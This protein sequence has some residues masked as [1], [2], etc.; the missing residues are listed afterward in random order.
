MLRLNR[1]MSGF[2]KRVSSS[3]KPFFYVFTTRRL[4]PK[5]KLSI[6]L[7]LWLFNIFINLLNKICF[8]FA[9]IFSDR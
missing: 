3:E 5:S 9:D 8:S 2:K 6:K 1:P 7:V 4:I